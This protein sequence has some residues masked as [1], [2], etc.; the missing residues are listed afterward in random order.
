MKNAKKGKAQVKRIKVKRFQGVYYR[1]TIKLDEKNKA[2][3]KYNGKADRCFD[4]TY[5]DQNGRLIWEK[6]GWV[7]EGYTAAMAFQVRGERLRTLRHGD[8]L[9]DKKKGRNK[10]TLQDIWDKEYKEEKGGKKTYQE[11]CWR[12]DKHIKPVFGNKKLYEI[13]SAMLNKF[14]TDIL[15]KKGLS[16]QTTT[17]LLNLIKSAFNVG[18]RNHVFK[19]INPVSQIEYPST[20]NKHRLR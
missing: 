9:P 18:I 11:D 7:S 19:G 15:K 4:I 10:K 3:K 20:K 8:E 5:K 12:Y 17:H 1:K 13:S 2:V 6:V 14:K 16:A